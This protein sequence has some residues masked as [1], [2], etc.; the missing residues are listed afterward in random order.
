MSEIKEKLQTAIKEM[1]VPEIQGYIKEL[2]TLVKDEEDSEDD[3]KALEEMYG[4]LEELESILLAIEDNKITDEEASEVH[5]N[6]LKLMEESKN[7]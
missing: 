4:L 3:L 2:N 1:M 7:H 6:I 5:D